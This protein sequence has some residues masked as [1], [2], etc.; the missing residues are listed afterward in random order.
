MLFPYTRNS[1]LL[2]TT[3]PRHLFFEGMPSPYAPMMQMGMLGQPNMASFDGPLMVPPR[4]DAQLPNPNTVTRPQ[5]PIQSS[6]AAEESAAKKRSACNHMRSKFNSTGNLK[7][8][9]H[10]LLFWKTK[11]GAHFPVVDGMLRDSVWKNLN[12]CEYGI[13]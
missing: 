6:E 9:V 3:L 7:R 1:S 11:L 4:P 2:P 10:T 12:S 13:K 5:A 8:R